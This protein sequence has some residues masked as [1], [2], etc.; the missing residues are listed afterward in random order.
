MGHPGDLRYYAKSSA[1]P[2]DSSQ[3]HY[4]AGTTEAQRGAGTCPRPHGG[5]ETELELKLKGGPHSWHPN[6]CDQSPRN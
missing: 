4:T 3:T 5:S 1:A 2:I 6:N